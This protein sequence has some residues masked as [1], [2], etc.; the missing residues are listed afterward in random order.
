MMPERTEAEAIAALTREVAPTEVTAGVLHVAF[1][2][3]WTDRTI[4]LQQYQEHPRRPVATVKVHDAAGFVAAVTQRISDEDGPAVVYADEERT[5]LV[6]LLNDDHG[7]G[8]GWR[9]HRVE[10]A[11]RRRPEWTHWMSLD[12]QMVNQEQFASHIED[13]LAEIVDPSAADML[14]LAQTFHATTS[15]RFKG[16]HRLASGAR[17]L[18]YEEE[19]D[20]SAG[21]QPGTLAIPEW[22]TLTMRPFFGAEKYEVRARFRF[23]LAAGNLTLGYKLERPSDVERA[24]FGDVRDAVA[25]ELKLTPIAGVAPSPRAD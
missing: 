5:A 16:G 8:A 11:L 3:E 15:A 13:G 9:D 17:Q 10:L 12:G 21:D 1:P 4:D 25:E 20:A 6:A 19:I 14:D 24:A 2:P 18:V 22:I 23:K 7:L